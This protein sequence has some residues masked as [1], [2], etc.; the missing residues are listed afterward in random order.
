MTDSKVGEFY[1]FCKRE[2]PKYLMGKNGKYQC[3]C[4]KSFTLGEIAKYDICP[5]CFWEDDGTTGEHGFSPNSVD[6]AQARLNYKE[7]GACDEHS[8]QVV[9]RAKREELEWLVVE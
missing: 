6:L 9:R 5:V 2:D 4:C 3:P 1:A 8:Q 7:Y